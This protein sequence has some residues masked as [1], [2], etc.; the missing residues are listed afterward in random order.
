MLSL[1]SFKRLV[2]DRGYST[3]AHHLVSE[4][5]PDDALAFDPPVERISLEWYANRLRPGFVEKVT[6]WPD[7][8]GTANPGAVNLYP[9][10]LPSSD[11]INS[12]SRIWV[13][14]TTQA[15]KKLAL[16]SFVLEKEV[17]FGRRK[18]SLWRRP[19]ESNPPR[20]LALQAPRGF[21]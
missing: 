10:R 7:Q 15:Q 9:P 4:A 20:V 1:M 21:E 5:R 6:I 11:Q 2:V 13:F 12:F 18:I 19:N 8:F 16:D 17:P 3:A 14:E